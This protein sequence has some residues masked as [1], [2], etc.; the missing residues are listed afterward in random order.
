MSSI[1][2]LVM[3]LLVHVRSGRGLK[4]ALGEEELLPPSADDLGT[5]PVR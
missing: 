3:L 1:A 4:L 2:R 5:I